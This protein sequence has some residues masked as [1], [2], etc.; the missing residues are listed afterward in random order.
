MKKYKVVFGYVLE[1]VTGTHWTKHRIPQ[2][3]FEL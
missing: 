2:V 1:G 3:P